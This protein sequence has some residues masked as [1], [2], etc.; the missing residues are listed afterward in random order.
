MMTAVAQ[1]LLVGARVGRAAASLGLA[2]AIAGLLLLAAGPTGWRLGW[3]GYRL[4]FTTLMPYAFGCGVGAMALS[5]GALIGSLGS[6]ARRH[7]AVAMLGLLTGGAVAFFP[8]HASQLRST[9]PP[10][11]DI[12]TDFANPPSF[13]FAA[14]M[15]AAEQGSPAAY[16]G[17]AAALQRQYYPDIA[18]TV[19]DMPADRAFDRVMAV[20]KAK[21]WTIVSADRAAGIVDAYDRSFWFGFTDDIAIRITAAAN[22]S[23]VDIRS[24]ARQ[25][26]GDFGV[27]AARV[28][29][30]L[31]TLKEGT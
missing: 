25:G 5:T 26:R 10:M 1:R 12:T 18:P 8:W 28:R 2:L 7:A 14:A 30:F 31:T 11:H 16:P 19:L 17:A 15:R 24:G 23:R 22:G 3:W 6:A 21:S 29:A 4:A 9:T 27:N 13:E 20:I